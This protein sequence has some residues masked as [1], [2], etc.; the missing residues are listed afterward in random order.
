MIKRVLRLGRRIGIAIGGGAVVAAGAVMLVV[1]GPG[2]LTI[3]LG[4]GILSL[5]FERPRHWLQRM[6]EKGIEVKDKFLHR[7]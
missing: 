7:Q 5:E 2:I 4:L 3:A 6:K 1:P